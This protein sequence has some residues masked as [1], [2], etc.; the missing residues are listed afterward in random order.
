VKAKTAKPFLL[1]DQEQSFRDVE[2]RLGER[3]GEEAPNV[4]PIRILSIDGHPVVREGIGAIINRQADVSLILASATGEE[5]I[6]AYRVARPDV[7]LL[8]LQLP[9]I[10]GIEVLI[11]IRSEFPD[12]RIII[13]STFERDVEIRR[14]LKAGAYGYLLK[15]VPPRE[16]LETIR[17]VH[18]GHK[19]VPR[20]IAAGLALHLSDENLS[21][22]EIEVLRHVAEGERNRDIGENLSIA[23]ETVKVHLK[24]IMGKL[25]ARDRTHSVAIAVR[26]GFL[27]L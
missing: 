17:R 27:Y 13:L 14:A 23:E 3:R 22:R 26:R 25:G 6:E 20:D 9:D 10:G 12:A 15:S 19:C 11:R 4:S 21:E 5:G 7:T 16:M 18:S 24:R 8:D 1:T 2:S